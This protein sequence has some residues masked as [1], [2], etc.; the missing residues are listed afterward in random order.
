MSSMGLRCRLNP[1]K[2]LDV[3]HLSSTQLTEHCEHQLQIS[4]RLPS[5]HRKQRAQVTQAELI[6]ANG[7]EKLLTEAGFMN[8]VLGDSDE[9]GIEEDNELDRL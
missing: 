7:S 9:S 8:D 6:N 3:L 5:R 4:P 2:I 1:E